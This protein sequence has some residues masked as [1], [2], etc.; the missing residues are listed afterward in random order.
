[1]H[2]SRWKKVFRELTFFLPPEKRF[3]MGYQ[4][5]DAVE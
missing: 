3:S 4:T 5:M 1:V 2:E